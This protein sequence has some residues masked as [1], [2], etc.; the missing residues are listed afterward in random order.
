MGYQATDADMVLVEYIGTETK[1]YFMGVG[2]R[3]R[4]PFGTCIGCKERYVLREDLGG[5]LADKARF[6]VH[7]D[8]TNVQRLANVVPIPSGDGTVPNAQ[9]TT[10]TTGS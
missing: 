3:Q 8:N 9:E 4:Y 10:P 6:V 7:L 5:F 2:S 1:R